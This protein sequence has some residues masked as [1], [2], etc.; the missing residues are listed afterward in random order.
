MRPITREDNNI[1]AA[2]YDH[3]EHS[4][5]M[6]VGQLIQ[7]NEFIPVAI[8]LQGEMDKLLNELEPNFKPF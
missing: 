4:E 1:A 8:S 3:R 6:S 7:R 2:A 5:Q